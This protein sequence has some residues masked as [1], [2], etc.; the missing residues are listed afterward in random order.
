MKQCATETFFKEC[1]QHTVVIPSYCHCCCTWTTPCSKNVEIRILHMYI[2]QL[3][4]CRTGQRCHQEHM[5]LVQVTPV[6]EVKAKGLH[7][8]LGNLISQVNTLRNETVVYLPK[9]KRSVS[10]RV[11]VLAVLGDNKAMH[12]LLGMSTAF[13]RASTFLCR[14]CLLHAQR[15]S[16]WLYSWP[17]RSMSNE[18][19]HFRGSTN[20]LAMLDNFDTV[21]QVRTVILQEVCT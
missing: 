8:C 12:E 5:L 3:P 6:S 16:E 10:I 21:N 14:Y 19:G 17:R 11:E 13:S 4:L 9:Q 18:D 2:C 15:F 7:R 20:T 1:N